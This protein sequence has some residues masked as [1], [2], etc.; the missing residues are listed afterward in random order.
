ESRAVRGIDRD[1]AGRSVRR[2]RGM[3]LRRRSCR[4]PE[5][6]TGRHGVP[7]ARI[8]HASRAARGWRHRRG[9]RLGAGRRAGA[10]EL[11]Q[12]DPNHPGWYTRQRPAI[13]PDQRRARVLRP[14]QLAAARREART[15]RRMGTRRIR[16]VGENAR[17]A[18]RG[19]DQGTLVIARR[20]IEHAAARM[21]AAKQVV[22]KKITQGPALPGKLA[23]CASTDPD[24]TELF[25]VEGDSAG[26]SAKQA[27]DKDYQ[28]ILPLRGKILNTWEVESG[29][30]L[31]SEEVH[32]LAIA[33]G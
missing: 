22:R 18:V 30:V 12:P 17:S 31:A 13:G 1:A 32:N 10:G 25:L 9:V 24:R 20:A 11:R 3:A 33:I 21:K 2:T 6:R 19:S 7:A 15:R 29:A 8:V 28:A 23:D 4:I 16:T 5:I 26:G 14:A 27:R